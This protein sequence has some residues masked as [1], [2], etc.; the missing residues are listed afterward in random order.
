MWVA[1]SLTG[2]GVPTNSTALEFLSEKLAAILH[3]FPAGQSS[4]LKDMTKPYLVSC[5][6]R[7][8]KAPWL[9]LRTAR[10]DASP[11]EDIHIPG[12]TDDS[13]FQEFCALI[14][15]PALLP[16]NTA[17]PQVKSPVLKDILLH[18]CWV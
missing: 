11:K 14:S 5:P 4:G 16:L 2:Q 18:L 12:R 6:Y 15:E 3:I 1:A 13:P 17:I 9:E 7:E 10:A 8:R